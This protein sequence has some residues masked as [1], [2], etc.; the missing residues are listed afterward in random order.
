MQSINI[1]SNLKTNTLI[2][3]LVCVLFSRN[4][5]SRILYQKAPDVNV[6]C[7]D[8]IKWLQDV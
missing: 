1:Y 8:A 3:Y 6:N 5:M 4:H 7:Q 2:L